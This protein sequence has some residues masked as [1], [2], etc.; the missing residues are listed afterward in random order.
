MAAVGVGARLGRPGS[1]SGTFLRIITVNDV[2]KLD[3]YPRVATAIKEIKATSDDCV[4]I[5]T[6]PGDFL[7]P[8]TITTLDGGVAMLGALNQVPIDYV[9]FGNHEFD[10]KPALLQKRLKEFKGTWVNS[11]VTSPTFMDKNGQPLP[12]YVMIDVGTHKVAMAAFLLNDMKQFAPIDQPSIAP[13]P[14]SIQRVWGQI[15]DASGQVDV[16]LPM[17]HLNIKDDR[18]IG[19]FIAKDSELATKTP[20]LLCSHD[21]EVFIEEAGKSLIFKTGCDAQNIGVIDIWWTPQG[22][23]KRSVHLFDI[24]DFAEDEEVKQYVKSKDSVLD[25]MLSVP[26]TDLPDTQ[27]EWSSVRVRFEAEPLATFLLSLVKPSMPGVDLVMLQGGG[28]RGSSK[29]QP[30]PFTYGDLMKEFAFETQ[31][32]CAM[33]PGEVIESTIRNSR[34]QPDGPKAFFLHCDSGA[35]FSSGSEVKLEEINGEA[36]DPAK[37]Y[38]V[39]TYQFLLDGMGEMEPLVSYVK[40][41]NLCPPLDQCMGIKHFVIKTCMKRAWCDLI[42]IHGHCEENEFVAKAKDAFDHIDE[43]HD[44]YIEPNELLHFVEEKK[45][46]SSASFI[47]FLIDSLDT[48]HDGKVDFHEL[49]QLPH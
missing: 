4:A 3:N 49:L 21:H 25:Q 16:F 19:A 34:T 5:S 36:F 20:V 40:D 13:V 32:G 18:Q 24:E 37:I 6:L 23:L 41:N 7:S 22:K 15:K 33:L 43:N 38:N 35:V 29:Y 39:A 45:K 47:K 8:C 1:A 27:A 12:E 26:I 2:Y 10:L 17:L 11:N 48:N 14:E 42:D 46:S 31:I 9:M 44:G 28:V 30:G